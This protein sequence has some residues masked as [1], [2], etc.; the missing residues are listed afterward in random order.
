MDLGDPNVM[1]QGMS[2]LPETELPL[3]LPGAYLVTDHL[4]PDERGAA[5][6]GRG[7]MRGEKE[8]E[9]EDRG[10]GGW[11]RKGGVRWPHKRTRETKTA[12][13]WHVV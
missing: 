9:F 2:Q 11:M 1:V 6:G 13:K 3:L 8:E 12:S 5:T 7:S 4:L 10:V